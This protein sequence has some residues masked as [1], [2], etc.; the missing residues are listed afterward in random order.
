M[1][2]ESVYIR[3]SLDLRGSYALLAIA[4]EPFEL[5]PHFKSPSP[6]S[7]RELS[8]GLTWGASGP[9]PEFP[10][11]EIDI[12]SRCAQGE[13]GVK[14][15]S[16]CEIPVFFHNLEGYDSHLIISVAALL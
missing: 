10:A 3:N 5:W 15:V 7:A 1:V 11:P 9:K 4:R 8:I 13:R 2:S 12:Q 14:R 6:V 16:R